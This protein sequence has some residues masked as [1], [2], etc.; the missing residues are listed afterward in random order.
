NVATVPVIDRGPYAH[1]ANWDLTMATGRALG[2]LG[3]A[4]IGA[5]STPPTSTPSTSTPPASPAGR[6]GGS[7]SAQ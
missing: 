7:P 4:V 2:M 6:G 1:N 3:T 5:A